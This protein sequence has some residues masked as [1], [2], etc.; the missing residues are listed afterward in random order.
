MQTS[1]PKQAHLRIEQ[2]E[3]FP[4]DCARGKGDNAGLA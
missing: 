4:S 1:D 3:Q 2:D